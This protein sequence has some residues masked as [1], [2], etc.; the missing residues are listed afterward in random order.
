[1]KNFLSCL[2]VI[3]CI[4]FATTAWATVP[5][6]DDN[7]VEIV[8]VSIDQDITANVVTIKQVEWSPEDSYTYTN[9]ALDATAQST[10]IL[11]T[12]V[13][14]ADLPIPDVPILAFVYNEKF[15][16]EA[17]TV[18]TAHILSYLDSLVI[19]DNYRYRCRYE[20]VS[21]NSNLINSRGIRQR[22]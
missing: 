16:K 6:Q 1:M 22:C 9:T 2:C 20:D 12:S 21:I 3:L 11:E 17:A 19:Q 5:D 10:L 4:G 8:Q 15:T 13:D 14:M 7:P 18:N